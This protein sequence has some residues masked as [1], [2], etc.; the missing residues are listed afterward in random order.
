MEN[1]G[2][3]KRDKEKWEGVWLGGGVKNFVVGSE[4]FLP[5]L[6]KNFF[7]QNKE[8]TEGRKHRF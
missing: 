3:K 2:E 4:Y 7:L 8:K 5:R 1:L 6:T